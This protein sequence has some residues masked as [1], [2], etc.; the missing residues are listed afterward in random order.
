VTHLDQLGRF[1]HGL[2][3]ARHFV[4]ERSHSV[5]GRD[6]VGGL[7]MSVRTR[8]V[9]LVVAAVAVSVG[10]VASGS[11]GALGAPLPRAPATAADV[12]TG[13]PYNIQSRWSAK[14]IDDPALSTGNV[15]LDQ[16]TCVYQSNEYWRLESVGTSVYRVRNGWS[17]KCM[18]IS[19]A[20][21][22]PGAA[23][24]QYACGNWNNEYFFFDTRGSDGTK[25]YY[26]IRSW[27]SNL[28]LNIAGASTANGAKVIQW[29]R[30]GAN[31]SLFYLY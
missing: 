24:I 1:P 2:G 3:T 27:S 21:L 30:C 23:V 4:T 8:M 5:R 12:Q 18:N 13:Y 6:E 20:S 11:T 22:D 26:D 28:C 15:Q 31:N 25:Y 10:A 14:C 29:N 7:V 9:C 17:N 19:H 16:W